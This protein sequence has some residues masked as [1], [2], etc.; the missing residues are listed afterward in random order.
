MCPGVIRLVSVSV[1]QSLGIFPLV[2]SL[3]RGGVSLG[4]RWRQ[5]GAVEARG[6]VDAG[7]GDQGVGDQGGQVTLTHT[8]IVA[9]VTRARGLEAAFRHDQ[10]PGVLFVLVTSN[11][12]L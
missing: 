3:G 1:L 11:L 8:N 12:E 4:P 6:A 10:G 9:A 7:G 5:G 2:Q